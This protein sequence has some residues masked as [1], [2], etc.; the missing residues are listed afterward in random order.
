MTQ[1]T[2]QSILPASVGGSA[3]GFSMSSAGMALAMPAL[4]MLPA[5]E[6]ADDRR[7]VTLTYKPSV[8]GIELLRD[9]AEICVAL[10]KAIL[11]R[12]REELERGVSLVGPHRDELGLSIGDLPAKGYASHGESWSLALALRLADHLQASP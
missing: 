8:E 7:E 12:R 10:Q 3:C 9:P 6:A 1:G 11:D 2:S 4:V 5:A